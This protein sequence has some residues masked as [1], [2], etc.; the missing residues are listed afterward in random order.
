MTRFKSKWALPHTYKPNDRIWAV[1]ILQPAILWLHIVKQLYAYSIP[2]VLH[3]VLDSI[4]QQTWK[5]MRVLS[6]YKRDIAVIWSV[7]MKP[8][9][10]IT[11]L[12][13][14]IA[15]PFSSQSHLQRYPCYQMEKNISNSLGY[16]QPFISFSCINLEFSITWNSTEVFTLKFDHYF[17]Y[18]KYC[19]IMRILFRLTQEGLH[20]SLSSFIPLV[21][22]SR[23]LIPCTKV[24]ASNLHRVP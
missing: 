13:R 11:D 9:N 23:Q 21:T 19:V 17:Y 5:M 7:P 22:L 3:P 15:S 4:V 14:K 8:Y 24:V 2:E 20:I 10:H 6:S 12:K 18:A 16:W 1:N